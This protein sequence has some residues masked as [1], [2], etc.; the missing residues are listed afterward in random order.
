MRWLDLAVPTIATCLEGLLVWRLSKHRL[1]L[2]YPYLSI[3]A[4]YSFARDVA[5][6]PIYLRASSMYATFFWDTAFVYLLLQFSLN[7]EFLRGVFPR[8][9]PMHHIAW[10][11]TVLVAL[12][13]APGILFLSW[14]Q[15]SSLPA[16]YIYLSP[17][18]TQ[19]M[20]LFQV[21]L[22]LAPLAVARY[23]GVALGRNMRGLAVGFGMYAC[24]A[25]MNFATVQAFRSFA[26][27]WTW[28][29]PLTFIA[30]IVIW[31]R[32]FWTYA[33]PPEMVTSHQG[34]DSA[35]EASAAVADTNTATRRLEFS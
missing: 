21:V 30:M 9:S 7:W 22:L 11:A 25:V 12:C 29:S 10:N 3:V 32:A 18:F 35:V 28:V 17:V 34:R 27:Y 15:V 26:P 19:Y 8:R 24:V 2:R 4:L 16:R 1:W 5:M 14:G 23:Y 33:P 13:A 6:A 20:N 31:L